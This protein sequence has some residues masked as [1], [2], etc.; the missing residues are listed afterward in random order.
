MFHLYHSSTLEEAITPGELGYIAGSIISALYCFFRPQSKKTLLY[1]NIIFTIIICYMAFGLIQLAYISYIILFNLIIAALMIKCYIKRLSKNENTIETYNK[2]LKTRKRMCCLAILIYNSIFIFVYKYF[3]DKSLKKGNLQSGKCKISFI[4]IQLSWVILE[5]NDGTSTTDIL[6]YIFL[7]PSTLSGHCPPFHVYLKRDTERLKSS[8]VPLSG[9]FMAV[10]FI[11]G[12]ILTRI[13][14]RKEKLKKIDNI[15]IL[16]L[17]ILAS[18]YSHRFLYYGMWVFSE[19]SLLYL[20]INY[21]NVKIKEIE[22]SRSIKNTVKN[23]NICYHDFLKE[24]IFK[25]VMELTDNKYISILS[26]YFISSILLDF[27]FIYSIVFFT[28][29]AAGSFLY[30]YFVTN[31]V[32]DLILVNLYLHNLNLL[33]SLSSFKLIFFV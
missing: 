31:T 21:S 16:Q 29:L 23:F 6:N 32:V 9:Y 12:S 27:K 11:F 10:V 15:L 19:S 3:F 4:A 14:S 2:I 18:G 20:G 7:I 13:P 26:C 22:L 25:W 24:L 33:I 28:L 8:N 17:I 30:P 5:Y 1:M